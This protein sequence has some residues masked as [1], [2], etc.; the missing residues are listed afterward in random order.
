[1][2][3]AH[4]IIQFKKSGASIRSFLLLIF[5]FPLSFVGIGQIT[6]TFL[7]SS[8]WTCPAGVSSVTVQCWGG[9]GAGGGASGLNSSNTRSTGGGGGGGSYAQKSISVTANTQYTITVGA[10]GIASSVKPGDQT[11]SQ[12]GGIS[13]FSYG[14]E[15]VKA[16][17]GSGGQNMVGG[18]D[19]PD[20]HK[21]LG[22][23]GGLTSG[24][25]ATTSYAGGNGK[26]SPD[27]TGASGYGGGG[28]SSAGSNITGTSAT[29]RTG[30]VANANGGGGNGANGG[31]SKTT[32]PNIFIAASSALQ[33]SGGGGGG[34]HANLD[35]TWKIGG[36]GGSGQV[37]LTYTATLP[38]TLS[39][40]YSISD[41]VHNQLV[42]TTETEI[43][44]LGFEVQGSSNRLNFQNIGFVNSQ[45][46]QNNSNT[47]ITY[48][49]TDMSPKGINT[50]YR[51]NQI[52]L[53][54][55]S[56]YSPIVRTNGANLFSITV[57][58]LYPNPGND[59]IY[60]IIAS[61]EN[62]TISITLSEINGKI[63]K[64]KNYELIKKNNL[65]FFDMSD[66]Q[67]G[68]YIIKIMKI[69][70][71]IIKSLQFIKL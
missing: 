6:E 54:G 38:I 56:K 5:I 28:G 50:Y 59:K 49:F 57:N 19:D 23:A 7:S 44:N 32:D 26:T 24:N 16:V 62:E 35:A 47:Q 45:S 71:R 3:N 41:G 64:T 1:M 15:L 67:S 43:N 53:D 63:V 70:G 21:G 20:Q 52:D 51:L 60:L 30:A 31:M 61:P 12:S 46:H 29:S 9:G 8:T 68:S 13:N 25:V 69:N 37:V 33:N 66:Q 14:S 2:I 18:A 4:S 11:Y 65:I 10:G 17:G 36:N 55:N 22:G 39:S 34:S 58:T 48:Y 40:F 42:W 27:A